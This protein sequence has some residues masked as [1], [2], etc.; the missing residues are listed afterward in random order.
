MNS[1]VPRTARSWVRCSVRVLEIGSDSS[2]PAEVTNRSPARVEMFAHRSEELSH[3][4]SAVHIDAL[5]HET[6]IGRG[7]VCVFFIPLTDKSVA[8]KSA[9]VDSLLGADTSSLLNSHVF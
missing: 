8:S 5:V 4:Y 2:H 1:I 3:P 7:C 6:Y 9:N